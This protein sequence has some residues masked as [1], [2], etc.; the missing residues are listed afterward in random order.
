MRNVL[1]GILAACLACAT[2]LFADDGF[3]GEKM[4]AVLDAQPSDHQLRYPFRHPAKTM[5]FFGIAP[6]SVVVEAIPGDGWYSRILASYL[7]S[8]GRLIGADY[9]LDMFPLF[10]FFTEQQLQQRAGWSRDW[11]EEAAE[12]GIEDGAPVSAFVFGS[13]PEDMHGTADTVLLIR[14]LH[15]LARFE[16]QGGFLTQALKDTFDIL[17]PGGIVGVVQHEALPDMPDDWASGENGYLKQDAVIEFM[18]KAGFE[19]VDASD[20]NQNERDRPTVDEQVWRLPPTMSTSRKDLQL[21]S[22][23]MSVG[24]SNRMT[25]KFCKPAASETE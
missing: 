7:G 12:W 23:M 1:Y 10:G 24:E 5:E 16:D 11:P 8:E 3:D 4:K 14:S 15:N 17:K 22:M 25:L 9:S 20:I 13:L 18:E 19:Y 2:P 6:G 21:R